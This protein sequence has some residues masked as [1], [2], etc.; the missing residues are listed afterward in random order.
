V[1]AKD[2]IKKSLPEV[3][4]GE[5]LKNHTTFGIG[6]P[7]KY[8]LAAQNKDQLVAALKFA[9]QNKMQFFVMGG[10]SNLLFLDE[11]F[12]GLVIQNEAGEIKSTGNRL[13]VDA[14]YDLHGVVRYTCKQGLSGMA[15]MSWIPGKIGGAVYGNAGAH[16]ASMSDLVTQVEV[17]DCKTGQVKIMDKADCKFD[18]RQSVFKKNKDLI[19]LRVTLELAAGNQDKLLAECENIKETRQDKLPRL[20]SAGCVFKNVPNDLA[21]GNDRLQEVIKDLPDLPEIPAGLLIDKVG[22]KGKAMGG[23]MVSEKHANFIV[24]KDEATA[25]EVLKLVSLIKS[26]VRDAFGIELECEIQVIK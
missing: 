23:A 13:E 19:V 8:Y 7:A 9:C 16:G 4:F 6:G 26:K 1:I 17:F 22:L 18:Y 25:A 11:G 2:E 14:G 3:K 5:P 24:N 12:P 20:P 10:G 21:E 15:K